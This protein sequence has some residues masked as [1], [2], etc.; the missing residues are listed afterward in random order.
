MLGVAANRLIGGLNKTACLVLLVWIGEEA[1]IVS[2]SI[3]K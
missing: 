1:A 3:E 2:V